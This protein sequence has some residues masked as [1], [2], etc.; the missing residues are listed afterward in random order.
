MTT[1]EVTP[2]QRYRDSFPTPVEDFAIEGI[3]VHARL[4]SSRVDLARRILGS[5]LIAVDDPGAE[6]V[7]IVVRYPEVESV[8]QLLQ[9]GDHIRVTAPAEAI[10]RIRDLA[11]QLWENHEGSG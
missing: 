2:S 7:T 1:T 4:R 6:W 3:D 11:A 9:F 10:D 8:R 5:R